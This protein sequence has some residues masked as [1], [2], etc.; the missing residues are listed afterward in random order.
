MTDEVPP[1]P[2]ATPSATRRVVRTERRERPYR[3]GIA[4]EV[5]GILTIV[6]GALLSTALS[7]TE[8][9]AAS[10]RARV[11]A[12]IEFEADDRSYVIVMIRGE[13]NSDGFIEESVASMD[14]TVTL[15]DGTT[16]EPTRGVQLVAERSDF[17]STIANFD[18]VAGPTTVLCDGSRGQIINNYAVAP[19]RGTAKIVAWALVGLG[20][21][22]VVVGAWLMAVG[23]RGRPVVERVPI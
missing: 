2:S 16:I 3:A 8:V 11:G 4:L 23:L 5:V 12:P 6:G 1:N 13:T 19:Y 7:G 14:C 21:V 22:A 20:I 18:A 17:G 10:G 15:A 9:L